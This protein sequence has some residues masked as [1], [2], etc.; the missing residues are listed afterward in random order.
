MTTSILTCHLGTRLDNKLLARNREIP[1]Y[2]FWRIRRFNTVLHK[3]G[4]REWNQQNNNLIFQ[5][6]LLEHIWEKDKN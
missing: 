1:W 2:A 6:Q 3:A 5:V 4:C